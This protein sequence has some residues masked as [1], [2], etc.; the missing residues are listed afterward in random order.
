MPLI[1]RVSV[2]SLFFMCKISTMFRSRGV[3]CFLMH[4]TASTMTSAMGSAMAG[5]IFVLNEVRATQTSRSRSFRG[6]SIVTLNWSRNF[7]TSSRARSKPSAMRR[8]WRPSAIVTS[9]NFINS[10]M[11][12]TLDVVPS[13]VMSSCAVA[14]R[15]IMLAV[16]CWICISPRSTC[17]SLVILICPAPPTSIFNVPRGP[18]LL[19]MTSCR[20][21]AALRFTARA[22]D[23]LRTSALE[24]T[25]VTMVATCLKT[26]LG[27][28]LPR[29][30]RPRHSTTPLIRTGGAARA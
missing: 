10:P 12:I 4:L 7:R 23:A 20:P 13:P 11:N 16:G 8:G 30:L 9:A 21:F 14:A 27:R 19:F 22:C 6:S 17:P 24:L 5:E 29:R 2:M 1:R 3:F 25:T 15:A 28:T 18:R 26:Y